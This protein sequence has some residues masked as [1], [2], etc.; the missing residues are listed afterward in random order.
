MAT[1]KTDVKTADLFTT[2]ERQWVK[3]ALVNQVKSLERMM[4]K[5]PA[6]SGAHT[7]HAKDVDIIRSIIAK[8]H[9]F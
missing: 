6:G 5:Y 3:V 2:D 4:A 8:V 1:D 7:A 9:T